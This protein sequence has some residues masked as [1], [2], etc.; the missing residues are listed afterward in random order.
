MLFYFRKFI[1]LLD[2]NSALCVAIVCVC[3]T[4]TRCFS[5][6]DILLAD[7]KVWKLKTYH[8]PLVFLPRGMNDVPVFKSQ[9]KKVINDFI[10]TKTVFSLDPNTTPGRNSQIVPV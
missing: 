10:Q 4:E 2:R 1:F 7:I 9:E 5:S 6:L 3:D 8:P